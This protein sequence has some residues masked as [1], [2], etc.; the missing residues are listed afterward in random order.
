MSF[1]H[2]DDS[3]ARGWFH[4]HSRIDRYRE[5]GAGGGLLG[6][7]MIAPDLDP[8]RI[9]GSVCRVAGGGCWPASAAAADGVLAFGRTRIID[10]EL[11]A[12]ICCS[13]RKPPLVTAG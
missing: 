2:R 8:G 7:V 9:G 1:L 6:M 3:G 13:S 11:D 5:G 4:H 12:M 10:L